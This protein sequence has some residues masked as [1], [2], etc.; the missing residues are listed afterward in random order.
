MHLIVTPGNS[1]TLMF[2]VTEKKLFLKTN[3]PTSLNDKE[4]VG[5]V[6]NGINAGSQYSNLMDSPS[7][8][9]VMNL[10]KN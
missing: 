5:F 6:T 10:V 1:L 3:Y 9:Y 2:L 8:K 4:K 7:Y